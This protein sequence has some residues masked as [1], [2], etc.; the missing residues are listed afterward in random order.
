[1]N[2]WKIDSS[3]NDGPQV[4]PH[5][6]IGARHRIV[7]WVAD[8]NDPRTIVGAEQKISGPAPDSSRH[9]RLWLGSLARRGSHQDTTR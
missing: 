3:R 6:I 8:K 5:A 7:A 2:H 1:M 4:F 9:R